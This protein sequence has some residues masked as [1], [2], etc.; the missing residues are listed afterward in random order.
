MDQGRQPHRDNLVRHRVLPLICCSPPSSQFST[1]PKATNP[2]RTGNIAFSWFCSSSYSLRSPGY[3]STLLT[4]YVVLAL[5]VLPTGNLF[6]QNAK[7]WLYGAMRASTA[8]IPAFVLTHDPKY[9]VLLLHGA[10]YDLCLKINVKNGVRIAEYITGA[11]LE[12]LAY[13]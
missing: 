10:L 2:F 7:S 9:L 5:T 13:T 12:I 8:V 4:V 11:I 3:G 6:T 1:R